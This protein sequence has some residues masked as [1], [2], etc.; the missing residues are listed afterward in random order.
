MELNL[1]YSLP[2][3]LM[4]VIHKK[5]FSMQVLKQITREG[6]FSIF[7]TKPE[8]K[9]CDD[10]CEICYRVLESVGPDAWSFVKKYRFFYEE[11]DRNSPIYKRIMDAFGVA[12]HPKKKFLVGMSNMMIISRIG[13]QRYVEFMQK[14]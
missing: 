9:W 1:F 8:W 2:D 14:D 7:N 6:D 13:W 3:D 12:F 5:I 11:A 4:W 10:E